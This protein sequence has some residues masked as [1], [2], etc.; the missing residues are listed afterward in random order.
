MSAIYHPLTACQDRHPVVQFERAEGKEALI[1]APK[2]PQCACYQY[3]G[4]N[5]N[6]PVHGKKDGQA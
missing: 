3:I 1:V 4:D 5:P 2:E 6:C